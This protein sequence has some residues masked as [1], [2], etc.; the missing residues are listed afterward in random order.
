MTIQGPIL[1]GVSVYVVLRAAL[2][3]SFVPNP[4]CKQSSQVP[5]E[6]KV[7]RATEEEWTLRG[8]VPV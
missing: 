6:T 8:V 3:S 5:T 2:N 1:H 7:C 4:Y